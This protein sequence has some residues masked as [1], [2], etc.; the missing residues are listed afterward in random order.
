MKPRLLFLLFSIL[1]LLALYLF[2]L[3]SGFVFL[4]KDRQVVTLVLK[5]HILAPV[6]KELLVEVVINQDSITAGLS[7]RADLKTLDGQTLGG[8]LF[9]FK[10]KTKQN[11]WMKDMLFDLDICWLDDLRFLSCA[12]GVKPPESLRSPEIYSSLGPA[13]FVLETRPGLLSAEDL[14]LQLFL[15]QEL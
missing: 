15:K 9:V 5:E 11:F 8:M 13:N 6:Q 14:D 10:D 3:S 4:L 2:Y 1:L 7:N 12:R